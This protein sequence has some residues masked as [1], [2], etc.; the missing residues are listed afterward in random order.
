MILQGVLN[1]LLGHSP[2]AREALQPFAG[3]TVRITTPLKNA[4]LVITQD[5]R[6]GASAAE[7]EATIDLP[8]S[9]FIARTHDPVAAERWIESSG[10]PALA[11]AVSLALSLLRW[12]A[13]EELSA[14][15]GDVV[16]N[17]LLKLAGVVGGV[18][19][20]IGGRL[21]KTYFE[22]WRDEASLLPRAEQ[23][24]LWQRD[25]ARL[26]EDLASLERRVTK[27]ESSR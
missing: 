1:R 20:A 24:S 25:L 4:T 2:K 11:R 22:Y 7:A 12:D 18:P 19:G 5:G 26:Q 14:L 27:M 8:L 10:E 17:R 16:A 13:A 23:V 15:I 3:R 21:L 9:F 6:L